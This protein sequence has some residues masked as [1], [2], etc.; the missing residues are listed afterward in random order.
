MKTLTILCLAIL[1]F[2]GS[3]NSSQDSPELLEANKLN[4]SVIKLIV[5]RKFDEALPLAKKA[6]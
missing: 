1:L 4:E 3:L 2:S 5:Q 6:L